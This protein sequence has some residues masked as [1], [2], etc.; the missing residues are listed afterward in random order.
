MS[1]KSG[2]TTNRWPLNESQRRVLAITLAGIERDLRRVTDGLERPPA[3]SRLLRHVDPLLTDADA[4][5]HKV[6]E[7]RQSIE[8][9]AHDLDLPAQEESLTQSL[10]ASLLL[11]QVGVEEV[12]PC[13]LRGYGE[14][15]AAT[16]AYLEDRLPRL[17]SLLQQLQ[18]LLNNGPGRV[19]RS[20][21]PDR[22]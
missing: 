17:R 15:N 7:I 18:A 11:D 20:H 3:D 22:T 9:L 19:R 13:R 6:A 2:P 8:Q 4:T 16:A 1:Q 10:V 21:E 14:V 5:R 12:E